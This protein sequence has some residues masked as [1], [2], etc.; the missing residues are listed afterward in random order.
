MADAQVA[1]G[2]MKTLVIGWSLRKF[3]AVLIIFAWGMIFRM[4]AGDSAWIVMIVASFLLG[5]TLRK[6]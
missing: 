5:F 4:L 3:N 6:K 1:E 2:I